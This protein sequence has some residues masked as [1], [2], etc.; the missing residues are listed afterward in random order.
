MRSGK[1]GWLIAMTAATVL[2]GCAS[3]GVPPPRAEFARAELA[4]EQ[5]EAS[6]A[7]QYAPLALR[8]ARQKLEAARAAAFKEDY[9]KARYLAREAEV[10]GRLALADAQ[11]ARAEQRAEDTRRSI[12]VLRQELQQKEGAK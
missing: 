7:T 8:D 4:I 5:A 11:T 2:A 9:L 6:E 1:Y 10:D 3:R 12:E